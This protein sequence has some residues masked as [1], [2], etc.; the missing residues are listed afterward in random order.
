MDFKILKLFQIL[1]GSI[2]RRLLLRTMFFALAMA[3]ISLTQIVHDVRTIEPIAMMNFDKCSLNIGYVNHSAHV[4]PFVS[5]SSTWA[6]FIETENVTTNVFKE[7][8][9]KSLIHYESKAL[10]IGEDQESA[11][12]A[13]HKSGV[14]DAVG[15]HR[16]PFFS[17][18]RKGFVYELE[19][20][21]N[22]FDFVFSRAIDRISIPSLLVTEIERVLKP[23]G[24]GAMLVGSGSFFT[25]GLITS[26]ASFLRNSDIIHLCGIEESLTLV[27]F[28][29]RIENVGLLELYR[30]PNDC[31]SIKANKP[32]IKYMEP[33][34]GKNGITYLP[35]L[36]DISTRKRLVYISINVGEL[37]TWDVMQKLKLMY[38]MKPGSFNAYVIDHDASAMSLYLKEP[39]ITF[40]Y[41]PG[42]A[43]EGRVLAKVSADE[44]LSAPQD[45]D[46][47]DFVKW[48]QETVLEGD[49][50]ILIMNARD[51]E[52]KMLFKMFESG[53]ICK[54][55]ELFI[56]CSDNE[57]CQSA[58]CG[59]CGDLFAGLR[60][61]GVFAHR[62][63]SSGGG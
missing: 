61:S 53:A 9:D 12:S 1:R 21:D 28:K 45:E 46:E 31:P 41:H 51:V 63:P 48:F 59:G 47:F 27:V 10:C 57:D 43:G 5:S 37:V 54:V 62:W 7:L 3:A 22:Q 50:V 26:S 49:F 29:K 34:D 55:D 40:V 42:L 15:V 44:F 52:L 24:T 36:I 58:A 32:M 35:K 13:L 19:F 16:H 17:L 14:S 18:A 6:R 11:I 8:L 2:A 20:G 60:K 38:P 56:H 25:A 33:M 39:G 30:L 4:L 23:G